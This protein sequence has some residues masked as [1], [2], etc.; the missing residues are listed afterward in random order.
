MLRFLCKAKKTLEQT[1]HEL[2][3]QLRPPS[4]I[5]RSSHKV[6]LVLF[7]LVRLRSFGDDKRSKDPR[8]SVNFVRQRR[9]QVAC[10]GV[11][12]CCHALQE[13]GRTTKNFFDGP[14]LY[15]LTSRDKRSRLSVHS[16]RGAVGGVGNRPLVLRTCRCLLFEP[17][18]GNSVSCLDEISDH[19]SLKHTSSV[20][21]PEFFTCRRSEGVS[22]SGTWVVSDAN[23]GLDG[24]SYESDACLVVAAF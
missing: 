19:L 8:S 22:L 7:G 3:L 15:L 11:I 20:Q 13:Q 16:D 10:L 21:F 6:G 2:C 5:H 4:R 24:H 1:M 18:L 14:G 23:N 17:L 12:S 9:E